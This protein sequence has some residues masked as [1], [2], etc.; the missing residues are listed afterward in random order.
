MKICMYNISIFQGRRFQI[1]LHDII[2][3]F[4][5]KLNNNKRKIYYK[6][7]RNVICNNLFGWWWIVIDYDGLR[8][9]EKCWCVEE[10]QTE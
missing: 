9:L 7:K 2:M 1:F 10:W 6:I 5:F 4:L 8:L 3:I